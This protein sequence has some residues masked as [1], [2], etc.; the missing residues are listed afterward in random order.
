MQSLRGC[1]C[2]T[3]CP[4]LALLVIK[5]NLCFFSFYLCSFCLVLLTVSSG[6]EKWM[7]PLELHITPYLGP[8]SANTDYL[9][10]LWLKHV[11]PLHGI[12][13]PAP[14]FILPLISSIC[15]IQ[16][17]TSARWGINS[18]LVS[19][20][21]CPQWGKVKSL[22]GMSEVVDSVGFQSWSSNGL[23]YVRVGF[24]KGV[25]HILTYRHLVT[26]NEQKMYLQS[27]FLFH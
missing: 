7:L 25:D 1:S 27:F 16:R 20:H 23:A 3:H 22:L 15:R 17:S 26:G 6:R 5:I 18:T 2:S 19:H 12:Y 14:L 4:Q 9:Q 24:D 10:C 8:T 13:C 11:T 21:L